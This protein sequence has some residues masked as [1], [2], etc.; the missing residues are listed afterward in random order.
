M[1]VLVQTALS[2]VYNRNIRTRG[3]KDRRDQYA[4]TAETGKTGKGIVMNEMGNYKEIIKRSHERS[5]R[6]GI[7]KDRP[8][9]RTHPERKGAGL[10]SGGE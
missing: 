10:C 2:C 5:V 6:Y 1:G 4:G 7:E 9:S 8:G 3:L